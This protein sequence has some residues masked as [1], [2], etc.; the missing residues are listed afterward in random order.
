MCL[1]VEFEDPDAFRR[2]RFSDR[3]FL[4]LLAFANRVQERVNSMEQKPAI[5]TNL[6]HTSWLANDS[7][8]VFQTEGLEK[9]MAGGEVNSGAEQLLQDGTCHFTGKAVKK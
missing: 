7:C 4:P 5:P 2:C 8:E 9:L 3:M 6:S 1:S